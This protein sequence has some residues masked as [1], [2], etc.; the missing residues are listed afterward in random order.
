MREIRKIYRAQYLQRLAVVTE[1]ERA[2]EKEIEKTLWEQ[3][4]VHAAFIL[5]SLHCSLSYRIFVSV[6]P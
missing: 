5:S 1:E 3:R 2:K 4:Q 6:A